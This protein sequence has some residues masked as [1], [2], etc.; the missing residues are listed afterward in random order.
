MDETS[1]QDATGRLP[2]EVLLNVFLKLRQEEDLGRVA[3]VSRRWRRL[4]ADPAVLRRFKREVELAKYEH[5]L[6]KPHVFARTAFYV[7]P[8][9]W[10]G[11]LGRAPPL[12]LAVGPNGEV[13]SGTQGSVI[14]KWGRGGDH[15]QTLQDHSGS[16]DCLA[17]GPGGVLY[18]G[19]KNQMRDGSI[20]VWSPGGDLIRTLRGHTDDVWSLAVGP[21]GEL[22]SG[23]ADNTIR[24]WSPAGDHL[25][26]LK[27]HTDWVVCLAVGPGG[28]LY[29]G[30]EGS[31]D[32]RSGLDDADSGDEVEPSQIIIWDAE[33]GT[34]LR[35]LR[36]HSET[37]VCLAVGSFGE[38]YSGSFDRTI[39]VWSRTGEHLKT[40]EGHTDGVTC[41]G[42]GLSGEIY[43]GSHDGTVRVWYRDGKSRVLRGHESAVTCLEV[44]QGGE[45]YSGSKDG[46]I[47][48]W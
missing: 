31:D 29:S 46:T 12:C 45:L 18:S 17:I 34:V 36:G 5:G 21:R 14:E 9:D 23:S 41:L 48:R 4:A 27:G 37:V 16:V 33:A 47:L 3:Q 13:W 7:S 25:K 26:T 8:S 22:Y 44:G 11:R 32:P 6:L 24:V 15:L 10:G 43:S 30:S 39:R 40:L 28:E 35:M 1:D 20:M 2:E 42:A 19:S 38:L